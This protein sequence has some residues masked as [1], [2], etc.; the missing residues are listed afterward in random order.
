MHTED[1]ARD[2]ARACRARLEPER[3]AGLHSDLDHWRANVGAPVALDA[4]ALA[5][6]RLDCVDVL[7]WN[8][9]IGLG[10]LGDL[11]HRLR[12][13]AFASATPAGSR[14]GDAR[15]PLVILLQEAFRSDDSVPGAT[16]S[17][18]HGGLH[19]GAV[20]RLDVVD[21]AREHGLS[22]RYSPSMRNG[23]HASDRG[24]A[25]LADVRLEDAHA[26]L[27]PYVRQRRVAVTAR[28]AGHP[29]IT[30]A[31]AHLDTHGQ[32]RAPGGRR[33]GGGRT[34]QAAALATALADVPGS[35]ILGADLNT[36]MGMSDPAIRA[37]VGAGMHPARRV[38]NWRHT[39]HTPLRLLLDHVMYRTDGRIR[40]AEVVRL[41]EA[42]G[43][44][45]RGVFGSD[46]HPLLARFE[47]DTG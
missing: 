22:L 13:G 32:P 24:N 3:H 6:Q 4:A 16:G 38:G 34:V 44:R 19:P 33:I 40:A 26:F 27:L 31:S 23:T 46:H 37:L 10:R 45:S 21:F 2:R 28:L 12:S 20:A 39:F 17:R 14:A 30:F 43:D 5:P 36:Y 11:L 35:L 47:L 9:A 41:D 15:V 18:H 8:V 7:C 25:V 42:P 1:A 29:G